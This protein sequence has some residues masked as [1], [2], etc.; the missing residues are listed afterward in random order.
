MLDFS[1]ATYRHITYTCC[2]FPWFSQDLYYQI[3]L[4]YHKYGNK[5][6]FLYLYG[7]AHEMMREQFQRWVACSCKIY[8]IIIETLFSLPHKRAAVWQ[9]WTPRNTQMQSYT[10]TI[11]HMRLSHHRQQQLKWEEQ[12]EQRKKL[13]RNIWPVAT[14]HC[15]R[16]LLALKKWHP[17]TPRPPPKMALSLM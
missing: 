6:I 1:E 5:I 9:P 16:F 14:L 4:C 7:Y 12:E 11:A 17:A 15:C 2:Y 10:N 8:C 13:C 3:Y